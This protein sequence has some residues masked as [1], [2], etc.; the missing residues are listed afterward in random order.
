MTQRA[1]RFHSRLA[2]DPIPGLMPDELTDEE[3]VLAIVDRMIDREHE[4]DPAPPAK[5]PST[6]AQRSQLHRIHCES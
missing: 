4:A 2:A 6:Q 3:Q 1:S 5:L